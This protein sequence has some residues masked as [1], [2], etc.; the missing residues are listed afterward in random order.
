MGSIEIPNRQFSVTIVGAGV[1]GLT[2]ALGLLRNNVPVTIYEAAPNFKSTGFGIS[3]GPAAHRAL[4]LIDPSISKAY[5]AL[6]TTHADSPGYEHFCR[7]W[8]ELVWTT[9]DK[10]GKVMT[11]LRAQ[12]LGQTSVHR[13]DFLETLINCLPPGKVRWGKNLI[14]MQEMAQGI[15][16]RFEDGS[17]A[18]ADVVIG[19]DGI[20]SRVRQCMLLGEQI[21]P[22]YAGMYAYRA[23]LDMGAMIDAVGEHRARV[24]TMYMGEGGYVVTYPIMRAKQVNVGLFKESD[25][26]NHDTWVQSVSREEMEHDFGH[27]GDAV[28]SILKHITTPIRWAVFDNP[29]ISTYT[30]NN[31]AILGDAAH[32]STPHQGAG[33]GQAIEDVHVLAELLGDPRVLR[34]EQVKAAFHAY[35]AMRR[36]RSQWVVRTSRDMGHLLSLSLDAVKGEEELKHLLNKRMGLLWDLDIPGQAEI[37][38]KVMLQHL[39]WVV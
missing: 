6:V 5:D 9:A 23:V 8:F 19:C 14:G 4:S 28:R 7:T 11:N 15:S 36:P 29:P 38:Q 12:T 31:I 30:R 3:M 21:R 20:H 22:Q 24:A 18:M 27:M 26:W 35:D 39:S 16:L 25:S 37:A 34:R 2:L 13:G 33:A 1:G 10:C 32:A 17:S